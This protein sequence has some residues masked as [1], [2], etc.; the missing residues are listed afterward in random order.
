[1]IKQNDHLLTHRHDQIPI[2]VGHI[3]HRR[4][5]VFLESQSKSMRH[6]LGFPFVDNN[7]Y[8]LEDVDLQRMSVHMER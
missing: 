6:V 7:F 3:S 2:D 4:F 1:M 5:C 8:H